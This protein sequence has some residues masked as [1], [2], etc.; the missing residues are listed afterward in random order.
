MPEHDFE[1]SVPEQVVFS[2][3]IGEMSDLSDFQKRQIVAVHL[4]RE[5]VTLTGQLF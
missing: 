3:E 1:Q 4:S 2:T 5:S